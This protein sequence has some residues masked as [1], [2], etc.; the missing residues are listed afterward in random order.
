VRKL[1]NEYD[2][3][4]NFYLTANDTN[5]MV[6]SF[7]IQAEP[8]IIEAVHERIDKNNSGYIEFE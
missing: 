4:N 3:N 7:N 2:K 8:A 6:K 5:Q 1:F